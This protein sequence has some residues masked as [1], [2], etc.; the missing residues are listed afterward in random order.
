MSVPG[1]RFCDQNEAVAGIAEML[2]Q[3]RA[4]V[5]GDGIGSDRGIA[6]VQNARDRAG[7]AQ[8]GAPEREIER[9]EIVVRINQIGLDDRALR[10]PGPTGLATGV[11]A[12]GSTVGMSRGRKSM[13]S[14]SVNGRAS[15]V[16]SS[17]NKSAPKVA[18]ASDVFFGNIG[19]GMVQNRE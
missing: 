4:H 15:F 7:R 18:I 6:V 13:T 16:N 9:A 14:E 10:A 12:S 3:K 11:D 1:P 17:T 8:F 19:G 5:G 2:L